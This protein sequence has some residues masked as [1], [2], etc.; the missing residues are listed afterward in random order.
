M[1]TACT[2]PLVV[3]FVGAALPI[4]SLAFGTL[5]VFT[6]A[7]LLFGSL[8]V[9]FTRLE[10]DAEGDHFS[11]AVRLFNR[12]LIR[13]GVR[14]STWHASARPGCSFDSSPNQSTFYRVEVTDF[15]GDRHL[16]LGEFLAFIYGVECL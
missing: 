11:L 6:A 12:P 7:I 16:V 15:D 1:M 2:L 13:R 14:G 5:I 10:L 4:E 9:L 8:F 3:L